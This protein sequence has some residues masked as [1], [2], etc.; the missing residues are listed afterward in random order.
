MKIKEA[1]MN[2]KPELIVMLTHD[3]YTVDNARTVFE[4]CKDTGAL[5]WGAKEKNLTH[6]ELMNLFAC[7]KEN[8]KKTVLEAVT[9][10]E[11]TGLDAAKLAVKCGCD[12]LMGT[13]FGDSISSFCQ[14]HGLKYM[15]FVGQ[16][17]GRPSIMEGTV[18]EIVDEA[19]SNIEKG[20]FGV[21][22]L[23]YRFVG[24]SQELNRLVVEAVDAPVCIAG[25]VDSYER[26]DEILELNPWAFTIGSAFFENRFGLE[27]PEQIE[28]VLSYINGSGTSR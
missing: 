18:D 22:L 8:G 23:G 3:D 10:N 7:M 1:S 12:M 13:V 26:L 25:S 6:L 9:Y 14:D 16:L 5:Y 15:P 27:F 11:A 21:D 24:N 19:R 17:R 4:S 2:R 20:A 28:N